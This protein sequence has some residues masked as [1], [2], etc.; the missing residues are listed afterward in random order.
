MGVEIKLTPQ[1]K[2]LIKDLSKA[3]KVNLKSA[4]HTIKLG[5]RKEVKAIFEK[6]QPRQQGLRWAALSTKYAIQKEKS[7]PG[8]TFN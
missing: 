6:Q 8:T 4:F 7:F 5:Y 3:G 1:S 2:K